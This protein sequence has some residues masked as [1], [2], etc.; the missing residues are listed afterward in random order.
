MRVSKSVVKLLQKEQILEKMVEFLHDDVALNPKDMFNLTMEFDEVAKDEPGYLISFVLQPKTEN[1][2]DIVTKIKSLVDIDYEMMLFGLPFNMHLGTF[3]NGTTL[4]NWIK[5]VISFELMMEYG[6]LEQK[7]ILEGKNMIATFLHDRFQI[8]LRDI[9]DMTLMDTK[10]GNTAIEFS[11]PPVMTIDKQ[12]LLANMELFVVGPCKDT[13]KLPVG[14]NTKDECKSCGFV[15]LFGTNVYPNQQSFQSR[16]ETWTG[17]ENRFEMAK[18]ERQLCPDHQEFCSNGQSESKCVGIGRCVSNFYKTISGSIE[19]HGSIRLLDLY[20][21]DFAINAVEESM[22][23]LHGFCRSAVR[24]SLFG[25]GRA[26]FGIALSIYPSPGRDEAFGKFLHMIESNDEIEVSGLT[27]SKVEGSL[28]VKYLDPHK[29]IPRFVDNDCFGCSSS[30][31]W[32]ILPNISLCL[33]KIQCLGEHALV[34][35]FAPDTEIVRVS[36]LM[37]SEAEF[38]DITDEFKDVMRQQIADQLYCS[39]DM[40]KKVN[41]VTSE[42]GKFELG[43]DIVLRENNAELREIVIFLQNIVD[44]EEF[45]IETT[46]VSLKAESDSLIYQQFI[47]GYPKEKADEPVSPHLWNAVTGGSFVA[48]LILII[49]LLVQARR[50]SGNTHVLQTPGSS[51]ELEKKDQKAPN[52]RPEI[53]TFLRRK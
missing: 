6:S 3:K 15:I 5:T 50:M 11:V 53:R 46:E 4:W 13:C 38:V 51:A 48:L 31:T 34:Q 36:I 16:Q 25:H 39:Q 19:V 41:M 35:K 10:E 49:I 14:T 24:A 12:V 1:T 17:N 40:L 20:G 43:F 42:D 9:Y 27:V 37:S 29:P 33:P 45:Y 30:E 7:G 22:A 44:S 32:C 23:T 21:I 28:S 47:S 8:S 18:I 26:K 52:R 2:N